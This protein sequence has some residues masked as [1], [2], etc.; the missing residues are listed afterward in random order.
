MILK[1]IILNKK[2]GMAEKRIRKEYFE[3]QK[4]SIVNCS[5][6]PA[7]DD[8]IY[9]WKGVIVGP[10]ETPYA[11]GVFSLSIIFPDDY[12]YRAPRVKFVTPIYHCNVSEGG[13]ICLDILK[14]KWSPVLTIGKVLLSICSLLS[15]PNPDDP[16]NQDVAQQFIENR[17]RHD[18]LALA[19]T[20]R[21][22]GGE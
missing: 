17:G 9:S 3:L 18:E 19:F 2:L 16:L 6:A 14:D 4:N 20:H 13:Q 1:E 8:D 7:E 5:A 15:D 22:A 21:F 12:P 10:E 11:G